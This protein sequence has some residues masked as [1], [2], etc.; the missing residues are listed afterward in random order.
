MRS[1]HSRARV[2]VWARCVR[3]LSRSA[4]QDDDWAKTTCPSIATRVSFGFRVRTKN[5]SL[6]R[7]LTPGKSLKRLSSNVDTPALISIAR[8]VIST[9]GFCVCCVD[10]QAAK[11]ARNKD[12]IHYHNIPGRFYNM[13]KKESPVVEV[14]SVTKVGRCIGPSRRS[15][16]RS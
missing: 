16:L 7:G 3:L 8:T 13:S 2:R 5:V 6:H 1:Q 11:E 9:L 15:R 10:I 12:A 14:L 4:S